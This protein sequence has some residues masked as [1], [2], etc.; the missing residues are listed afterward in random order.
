MKGINEIIKIQP[1]Y[2]ILFIFMIYRVQSALVSI[3]GSPREKLKIY[4]ALKQEDMF[5][6]FLF[7]IVAEGLNVMCTFAHIRNTLDL[8]LVWLLLLSKLICIL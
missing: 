8:Y 3:N 5:S 7:R 4:K 6:P 2:H 1:K